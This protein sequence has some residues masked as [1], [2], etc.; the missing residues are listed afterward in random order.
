MASALPSKK[1]RALLEYID[2]FIK[3]NN[4]A[5][6][7]REVMRALDYKSVSTVASHING[8]IERGWLVKRDNSARSVEVVYNKGQSGTPADTQNSPTPSL[9]TPK[10]SEDEL[11]RR[12]DAARKKVDIGGTY[13]HYKGGLYTVTNLAVQTDDD[14]V[15]VVYTAQYGEGLTYV[16][17]LREWADVVEHDG[18]SVERFRKQDDNN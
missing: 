17:S 13:I 2:G 3:E 6:S 15:A 12:L 16:R 18:E 10:I 9:P 11:M 1:Q 8:L 7:Y 14:E 4:F 5:P